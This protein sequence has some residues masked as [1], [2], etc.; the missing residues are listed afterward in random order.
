MIPQSAAPETDQSKTLD[1]MAMAHPLMRCAFRSSIT[2][3]D[4]VRIS[5]AVIV[6]MF[7][8]VVTQPPGCR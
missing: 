6:V 8:P 7:T 4:P 5:G 3:T 1:T 2:A